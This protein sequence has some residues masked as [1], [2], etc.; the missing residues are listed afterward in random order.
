MGKPLSIWFND[1][2]IKAIKKKSKKENR[3]I[4]NFIKYKVFQKDKKCQK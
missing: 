1:E 3:S 4:S 2:E